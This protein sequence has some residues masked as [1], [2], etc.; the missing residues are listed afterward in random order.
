MIDKRFYLLIQ[1]A[2]YGIIAALPPDARR[3]LR[4]AEPFALKI[5]RGYASNGGTAAKDQGEITGKASLSAHQAAQPH[6]WQ[7]GLLVII[8]YLSS[9]PM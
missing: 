3:R 7:L 9:I 1:V 6:N 5:L 2:S 8:C 4:L